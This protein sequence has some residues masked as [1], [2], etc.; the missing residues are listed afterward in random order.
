MIISLAPASLIVAVVVAVAKLSKVLDKLTGVIS[1]SFIM[2]L[3]SFF[4]VEVGDIFLPADL[5]FLEPE[6]SI[7]VGCYNFDTKVGGLD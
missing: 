6:C 1:S 3:G 2:D 5:F 7:L 4:G